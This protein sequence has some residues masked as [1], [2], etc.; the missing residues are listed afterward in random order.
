[1]WSNDRYGSCK[2][3][4][5]HRA[6]LKEQLKTKDMEKVKRNEAKIIAKAL[7]AITAVAFDGTAFDDCDIDEDSINLILEEIQKQSDSVFRELYKKY[8]IDFSRMGS[9]EQ[10][11]E[12]IIFE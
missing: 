2:Y 10:V 1:M 8:G 7:V 9:T 11:V 4:I 6:F 5:L 3:R 12:A